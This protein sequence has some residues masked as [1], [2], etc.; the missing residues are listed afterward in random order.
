RFE[1]GGVILLTAEDGLADT[2]RPRLDA[3]GADVTRIEAIESVS[4]GIAG[5][6]ERAVNLADDLRLIE[7]RI[8]RRGDVRL[9]VVDP[10]SAYCGRAD[11][12]TNAEVR[13]M[14]APIAKLAERHGVAIVAV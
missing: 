12:H 3:A 1:P 10:V 6:G 7:E 14:L 2:V 13:G 8:E 4:V 5:G 9:F 11:S